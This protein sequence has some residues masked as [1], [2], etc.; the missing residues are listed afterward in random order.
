[1]DGIALEDG[2]EDLGDVVGKDNSGNSPQDRREARDGIED[3]M[4]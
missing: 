1:M 2:Q 3:A 4:K